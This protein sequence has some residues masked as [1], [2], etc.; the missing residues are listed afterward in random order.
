MFE[1]SKKDVQRSYITPESKSIS[2]I[3]SSSLPIC[4]S[5]YSLSDLSEDNSYD[6]NDFF[7]D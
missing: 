3:I 7:L 2:L 5:G 4:T 1:K 6:W